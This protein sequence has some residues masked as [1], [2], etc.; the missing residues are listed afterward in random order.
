[1]IEVINHVTTII[2]GTINAIVIGAK[3]EL[4]AFLLHKNWHVSLHYV[5]LLYFTYQTSYYKITIL[6][7]SHE[8]FNLNS[9]S[10]GVDLV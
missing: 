3:G 4:D 9:V 2:H 1:M 7:N 5:F 10:I 8:F 6:S